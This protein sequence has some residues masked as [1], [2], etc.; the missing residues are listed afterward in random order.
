[1]R[2]CWHDEAGGC[3]YCR[4]IVIADDGPDPD[5]RDAPTP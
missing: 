5:D 2:P 1:M 3:P 4:A